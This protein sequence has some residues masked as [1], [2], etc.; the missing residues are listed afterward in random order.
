MSISYTPTTNF[1]A[2]DTLPSN[3]PD[4]VVRGSEFSTEFASIQT[5][6]SLAA[7]SSNPTFTGTVTLEGL[8]ATGTATLDDLRKIVRRMAKDFYGEEL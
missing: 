6:F 3:D 2:K 4:K 8:I 5:A 1:G 7:P